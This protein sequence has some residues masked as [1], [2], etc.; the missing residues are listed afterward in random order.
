[1]TKPFHPIAAKQEVSLF[2]FGDHASKYIPDDLN[3]LGLTGDDLTRHIAWDIGTEVI[4]RHL[5]EH[6]GCAGQLAGASRLVIDLN[7]DT[8][9]LSSIPVE[10]DGTA[11]PGNAGIDVDERQRRIDTYHTP[12]HA[13]LDC[14][15]AGYDDPLVISMHSFTPKPHLGEVRGVDIGLL[16]KHDE[17]SAEALAGMFMLMGQNFRVAMNEP[18]SAHAL[19]YTIDTSVASRGFRHLAIEINQRLIDTDVKA[20]DMAKILADRLEPIVYKTYH[21]ILPRP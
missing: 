15:L 21:S 17:E 16:V 2:V 11:I 20:L 9:M 8:E 18:Y 14:A 5:C 4:V 12:Y 13:A 19:N 3:N 6:F 1:M 7:R 10:S